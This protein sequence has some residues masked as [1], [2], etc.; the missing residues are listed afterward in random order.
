MTQPSAAPSLRVRLAAVGV[1]LSY[2]IAGFLFA[3]LLYAALL[4]PL[5]GDGPPDLSASALLQALCSLA[6]FGALTWLLGI[7]ATRLTPLDLRWVPGG[8]PGFSRGFGIGAAPAAGILMGAVIIAGARWAPDGGSALAWLSS[9]GGLV[10]LLFPAALAEE[11]I[12]RGVGLVILARAFGRWPAVM[13]MG[14]L[15]GV[16]HLLNPGITV[17]GLTNITLAGVFLGLVFYLP[18]GLW[19]ATG[20]HLGWNLTLA[21]LAAPVSGLPLPVPGIDFAPG[22]P[23][24]LT[25]GRFGPEGGVLATAALLTAIVLV[26]RVLPKETEA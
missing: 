11:V 12:F 6:S 26:A 19:T 24:W 1:T 22:G 3:G 8:V 16:A 20:A 5:F 23:L 15:F 2:L 21:A 10:G 18:G 7:R 4:P 17:T 25:G 9:V 14:V 13:A